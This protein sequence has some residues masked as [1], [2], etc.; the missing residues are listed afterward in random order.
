MGWVRMIEDGENIDGKIHAAPRAEQFSLLY[1]LSRA[2][3]S[4]I[5]LDELLPYVAAQTRAVLQAES[6]VIFLLDA[7]QQELYIPVVSDAI[8]TVES[9]LKDI[10]LPA[11]RGIVGWVV[12]QGKPTLVPD[13]SKDE[14]FYKGVDQRSG[15]HTRDL[16]YAPLRTRNGVIGAIGIRNKQVG[17]FTEVDLT[18]L[19]ALAGSIAI[20]IENARFYGAAQ[21]R[22]ELLKAEVANLHKEVV[23]RQRFTEIVG[24]SG[25]AMGKVFSLMETAIPLDLAV[26]LEGETGTGK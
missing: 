20:A 25:G 18:F 19:D 9:R 21:Q 3:S 2:F 12:Q 10:R 24:S 11:D 1:E 26:L 17:G 5:E 8:S 14:R 23:Q 13:V 22:A 6:C 7:A 16:L 15:A 4:L